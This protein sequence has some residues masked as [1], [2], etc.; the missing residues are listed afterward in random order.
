MDEQLP[1]EGQDGGRRPLHRPGGRPQAAPPP[2]DHLRRETWETQLWQ[3]ESSQ[4][5]HS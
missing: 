4:V 3:D 2:R 1:A 5:K